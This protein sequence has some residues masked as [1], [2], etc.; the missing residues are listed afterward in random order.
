MHT[1]THLSHKPI[2][3][4]NNYTQHDDIYKSNTD[5]KTHSIV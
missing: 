2:T 4:I 5:V 1:S 3:S